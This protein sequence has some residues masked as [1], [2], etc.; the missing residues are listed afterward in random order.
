MNQLSLL[1]CNQVAGGSASIIETIISGGSKENSIGDATH[2]S[3]GDYIDEN[4]NYNK[5]VLIGDK[6]DMHID[7]W[8]C[9]T[10][11]ISYPQD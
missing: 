1:E 7:Y 4:G 10:C 8:V 9:T 6:N 3:N 5:Y 2:L 11:P